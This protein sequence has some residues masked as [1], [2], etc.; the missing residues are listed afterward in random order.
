M[1]KSVILGLDY[2]GRKNGFGTLLFDEESEARAAAKEM[3]GQH[4]GSRYVDL[5]V[6]SYG[7]YKRFNSK[8]TNGSNLN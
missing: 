2:S 8:S 1:E 7:E 4:V 3:N 6:I 5:S